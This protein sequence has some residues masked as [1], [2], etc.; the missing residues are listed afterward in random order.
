MNDI[1]D[2]LYKYS[3]FK[4]FKD[5]VYSKLN[6][7]PKINNKILKLQYELNIPLSDYSVEKFNN[8]KNNIFLFY[9]YV[10]HEP[11]FY[12]KNCGY[13]KIRINKKLNYY[14]GYRDNY[15]CM[16]NSIKIFWIKSQKS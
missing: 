9:N 1:L 8:N 4:M 7:D 11:Y 12:D 15:L 14:D 16:I 13:K 6:L 3:F 5:K 2:E 10:P